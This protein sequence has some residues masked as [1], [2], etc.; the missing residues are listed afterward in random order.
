MIY[1]REKKLELDLKFENKNYFEIKR[2][3]ISKDMRR[4]SIIYLLFIYFYLNFIFSSHLF[5]IIIF[6]YFTFS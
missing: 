1:L 6:I 3:K 2:T 5:L 4:D